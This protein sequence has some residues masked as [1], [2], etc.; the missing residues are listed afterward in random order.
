MRIN[1]KQEYI[2]RLETEKI[3]G[4]IS[5]MIIFCGIVLVII[6]AFLD[7]PNWNIYR[8]FVGVGFLSLLFYVYWRQY[9]EARD[10]LRRI[11]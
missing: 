1:Y 4:L 5:M 6:L 7:D 8:V 3:T 11:K 2:D 10:K 9:K